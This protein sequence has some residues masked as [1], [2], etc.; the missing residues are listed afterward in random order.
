MKVVSIEMSPGLRQ[1]FKAACAMNN[2]SMKDAL[3]E[4]TKKIIYNN[5]L[6]YNT[7]RPKADEDMCLLCINAE[8]DFLKEVKLRK[9]TDGDKIRDIYITAIINYLED[10]V[11][12]YDFSNDVF[13]D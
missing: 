3:V 7:H 6:T 12:E 8:E 5:E 1:A 10:S 2:I 11:V 4:E 9:Q 13:D